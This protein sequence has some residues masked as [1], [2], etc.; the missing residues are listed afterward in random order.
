MIAAAVLLLC[1]VPCRLH[2]VMAQQGVKE[3]VVTADTPLTPILA[4]GSNAGM[5]AALVLLL[6]LLLLL[7]YA[8]LCRHIVGYVPCWCCDYAFFAVA[9]GVV[10]YRKVHAPQQQLEFVRWQHDG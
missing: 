10:G 5:A 6:L 8:V 2:E 3:S 9:L 1:F 7:P 4:I